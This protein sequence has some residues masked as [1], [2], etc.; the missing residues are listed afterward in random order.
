[1]IKLL[2]RGVE[3]LRFAGL[4]LVIGQFG[5]DLTFPAALYQLLISNGL[6]RLRGRLRVCAREVSEEFIGQIE[7]FRS[8]YQRRIRL[9]TGN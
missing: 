5:A 7:L 8:Q 9:E 2:A 4:E 1:L 6:G 3:H